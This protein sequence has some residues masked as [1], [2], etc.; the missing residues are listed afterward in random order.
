MKK[1]DRKIYIE[2]TD[3]IGTTLCMFCKHGYWCS[4]GCCEGYYTCEHSLNEIICFDGEL[5]YP[6]SDCWGFRTTKSID[7][8]ADIV[9]VILQNNFVEWN[10]VF[11][12]D[13]SK[14]VIR[15]KE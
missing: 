15:G 5:P 1:T 7:Y 14:V 12:A 2:L 10:I 8:I 6:G 11:D 4:N 9:S 13:I 3:I